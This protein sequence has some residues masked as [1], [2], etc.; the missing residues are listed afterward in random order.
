[1]KAVR[2]GVRSEGGQALVELA[3]LAPFIMLLV[4]G[5]IEMGRAWQVKQTLT[6]IAR[7]GAR[8]SVVA[9]VDVDKAGAELHMRTMAK[10]A[11]MDSSTTALTIAWPDGCRWS[12]GCGSTPLQTGDIAAVQLTYNHNFVA[13]HRLIQL[14]TSS[15]GQMVL[16]TASR[17]RVE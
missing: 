2:Q 4:I 12:S 8:V 6:D 11:G 13:L 3:L 1:M 14:A 15:N 9:D 7:E 10:S 17:M 5:V 16:S